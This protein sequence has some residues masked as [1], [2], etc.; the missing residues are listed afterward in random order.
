[1]HK[2]RNL[3]KLM[4]LVSTNGYIIDRFGPY[5]ANGH[6]NDAKI[7]KIIVEDASKIQDFFK[8]D[9]ICILDSGFRDILSYL[10]SMR[11]D[12]KIPAYLNNKI[13]SI[14]LSKPINLNWL[15]K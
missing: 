5:L 11:I 8:K 2:N 7:F 12:T 1:M 3:V 14:P 10:E 6:N 15:L 13:S 4:M 9:D